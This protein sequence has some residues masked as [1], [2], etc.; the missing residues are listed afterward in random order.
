MQQPDMVHILVR[1]AATV[2]ACAVVALI[3]LPQSVATVAVES[4]T[5]LSSLSWEGGGR[6]PHAVSHHSPVGPARTACIQA[7][8]TLCSFNG[9]VL[10]P[11]SALFNAAVRI[12]NA[13]VEVAPAVIAVPNN[14]ADVQCALQAARSCVSPFSVL[15]GGH[16]A[17]GY[18]LS[19]GGLVLSLRAPHVP[20]APPL[21]GGLA[22]VGSVDTTSGVLRVGAGARY[23]EVYAAVNGTEWV[24][25]GGG[26]PQVGVGGYIL[27]GGWSFLSR[28][29]GLAIDKLAA[30]ELVLAN[31]TFVRI[32]ASAVASAPPH[33]PLYELWFALRGGGGGNFGVA[34][35]FELQLVSNIRC[36]RVCV[37][38]CV[39]VCV[40]DMFHWHVSRFRFRV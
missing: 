31:G 10:L 33:S 30:V 5:S 36:A 37:C 11:G 15:S 23:G 25:I 1:H 14:V 40:S 13:R 7:S 29:Y 39:C 26:C 3:L 20:P 19:A 8:L 21:Q 16:S 4:G 24:P 27:G 17:A 12:D 18:G 22:G 9:R 32:E 28:S 34:T 38:V 35:A 2:A 6:P